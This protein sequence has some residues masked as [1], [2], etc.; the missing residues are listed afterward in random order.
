MI[1]SSQYKISY[2]AFIRGKHELYVK[3]NSLEL[4][5]SPFNI[6]VYPDPKFFHLPTFPITILT[7]LDDPSSII[8]KD[9]GELI[10]SEVRGDK[11]SIIKGDS[12]QVFLKLTNLAPS[13]I[14]TDADT[15]FYLTREHKLLK[16]N[17]QGDL[18]NHIGCNKSGYANN[19]FNNPRGV[20]LYK[21][22]LYVCDSDNHRIQVFDLNLRYN[23]TIGSKGNGSLQFEAPFDVKFDFAGNMYVAEMENE[24]VQVID[25]RGKFVRVFGEEGK[26]DLDGPTGLAIIDKYVY[27]ADWK[28]H[29]ITVY[30]T[31]GEFVASFGKEGN[32][33]GEFHYPY[34]VTAGA[35]GYIYV[36][37]WQ[38][39]RVQ[40]F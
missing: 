26:V 34:C 6:T 13:C 7:K 24:R 36:C 25:H 12:R 23:K 11:I 38:N 30:N 33:T 18:I 40:I 22:M 29:R 31:L 19:R 28:G 14:V 10:V 35:D 4:Q 1:S 5:G 32:G 27:V 16:F 8:V 17:H 39:E 20:T 2:V 3:V 9:S 15:N 21:E 37:D